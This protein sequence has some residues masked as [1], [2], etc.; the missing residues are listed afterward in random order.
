MSP[1][2][3]VGIIP[4]EAGCNSYL[5]FGTHGLLDVFSPSSAVAAVQEAEEHSNEKHVL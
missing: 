4:V 3:E 5:I 1:E 2:P